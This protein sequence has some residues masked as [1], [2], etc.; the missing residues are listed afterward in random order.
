MLAYAMY[1][2]LIQ[3]KANRLSNSNLSSKVKY[4]LS[5]PREA[6]KED[7]FEGSIQTLL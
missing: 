1:F 6:R 2:L 5:T 3:K 4:K 7:T